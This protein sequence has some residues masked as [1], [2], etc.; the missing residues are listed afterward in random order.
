MAPLGLQMT[1]IGSL[2]G[3]SHMMGAGGVI[4]NQDLFWIACKNYYIADDGTVTLNSTCEMFP[5]PATSDFNDIWDLDGANYMPQD[6]SSVGYGPE[7]NWEVDGSN[8]QPVIGTTYCC[9]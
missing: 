5:K 8:I 9:E 3:P 7:G 1:T 2:G 4:M 6:P